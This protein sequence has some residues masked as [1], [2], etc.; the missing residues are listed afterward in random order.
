ML[1]SAGLN[2]KLPVA[3]RV[4]NIGAIF[5]NENVEVSQRTKHVDC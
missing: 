2:V 4:D 3:I 5:M 1:K